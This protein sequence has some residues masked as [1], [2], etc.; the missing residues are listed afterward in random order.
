MPR[1]RVISGGGVGT[2]HPLAIA[3]SKDAT[4][5]EDSVIIGRD[6]DSNIV[7]ADHG[8]SR[9]HAEIFR[10]GDRFFLKDLDSKNGTFAND[11][12]I[13]LEILNPGD[14]VRIGQ[15]EFAFE[16]S[17][18]GEAGA[19]VR[20]SSGDVSA[21]T[22]IINLKEIREEQRKA[23]A[24]EKALAG[25]NFHVLSQAARIISKERN[26]RGLMRAILELASETIGAEEA[27]V[28]LV[29]PAGELTTRESITAK[30]RPALV[31]RTIVKRVIQ[32]HRAVLSQ[33]AARDERFSKGKSV[34]A[35]RVRSVICAPLMVAGKVSGVL[36]LATSTVAEGFTSENLELAT[37]IAIQLG[38]ALENLRAAEMQKSLFFRAIH[39]LV[40]AVSMRE[41]ATLGHSERVAG[42]VKAICDQL[43]LSLEEK[44][45]IQ[46]AGLL[47][48]IGKIAASDDELRLIN[49]DEQ[50][51]RLEQIKRAEKIV[52]EIKGL[53]FVLP[54][55]KHIYE[56]YD[57]AGIP[58]GLKGDK[59]PLM[60]RIVSVADKFDKLTAITGD[61]GEPILL[62]D[63]L[64]KLREASGSHL[65]GDIVTALM[66][67]YKKGT[68]FGASPSPNH[69]VQ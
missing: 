16:E 11:E 54:G 53:E 65:D 49:R 13:S 35:G 48:N 43:D 20:Y 45:R 23:A 30:G 3:S 38:L 55:I 17:P 19:P 33:D 18:A 27:H 1:L 32:Y 5:R 67:A 37:V 14:R 4:S 39:A 28:I 44:S 68:L 56:Q 58:D 42:Y 34:I 15:T 59:I 36:Y 24:K 26:E 22:M 63:A 6:V 57:G 47:H 29:S 7:V 52:R 31:S 8:V 12:Q 2:V 21:P 50:A 10:I 51:A 66:I 64:E 40:T 69:P 62:K 46:I 25:E 61:E 9:H 41:P 60:A